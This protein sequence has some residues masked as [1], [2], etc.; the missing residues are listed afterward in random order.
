MSATPIILRLATRSVSLPHP[1][2]VVVVAVC[3]G[4]RTKVPLISLLPTFINHEVPALEETV[5]EVPKEQPTQ[6]PL[7]Q[8]TTKEG[9][10]QEI[11]KEGPAQVVL[12]QEDNDIVL[13]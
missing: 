10:T 4:D 3:V 11:R 7:V 2:L 13:L 8:E 1:T 5:Q 6:E 9:P 12:V